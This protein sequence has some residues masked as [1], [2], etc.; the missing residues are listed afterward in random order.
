MRRS[1]M[2][3]L[4]NHLRFLGNCYVISSV[5]R[6][7][8]FSDITLLRSIHNILWRKNSLHVCNCHARCIDHTQQCEAAR[9]TRVLLTTAVRASFWWRVTGDHGAGD[10]GRGHLPLKFGKYIFSAN[11]VYNSGI[12]VNFSCIYFRAKCLHSCPLPNWLSSYAYAGDCF[13][14]QLTELGQVQNL[15]ERQYWEDSATE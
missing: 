6:R 7:S 11:I 9:G 13:C 4:H 15:V 1:G 10:G 2:Q 14:K 8:A 5:C 3:L 12:F